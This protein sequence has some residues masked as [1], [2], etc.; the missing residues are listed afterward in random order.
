VARKEAGWRYPRRKLL[1]AGKGISGP[2]L[3]EKGRAHGGQIG[4]ASG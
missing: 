4:M 1:K 3:E 2:L